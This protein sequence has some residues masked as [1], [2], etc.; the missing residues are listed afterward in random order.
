LKTNSAN[1]SQ[2]NVNPNRDLQSASRVTR[3]SKA[4]AAANAGT[5]F[6]ASTKLAEKLAVTP[7]VRADAVARAK[8]LIADPNY[9]N[10]ATVQKIAQRLAENPAQ[11]HGEGN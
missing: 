10:T 4:A 7:E 2:M 5:D 8:A 9:P 6:A 1:S 3:P 11:L